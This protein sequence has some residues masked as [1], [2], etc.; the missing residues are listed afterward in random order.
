LRNWATGFDPNKIIYWDMRD[1]R[2][3]LLDGVA[4][5]T[6][7]NK[8]IVSRDGT[9]TIGMTCYT[10][11]YV[12]TNGNWLC[13]L[14]QLT[15]VA[16][17]NYP[18][19]DTIVVRYLRETCSSSVSGY[20]DY[21][22]RATKGLGHDGS[23]LRALWRIRCTNATAPRSPRLSVHALAGLRPRDTHQA[24]VPVASLIS[25]GDLFAGYLQTQSLSGV[26]ELHQLLRSASSWQQCNASPFAIPPQ[27]QWA[28]LSGAPPGEGA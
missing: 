20:S 5:V 7:T 4:L 10:D 26:I 8:H 3:T 28:G 11:S 18:S 22:R 16:R 27:E 12:R 14:A 15:P 23:C 13:A 17:E 2:I 1:E 9:E 24:M 25:D 19:D 6:A 21:S